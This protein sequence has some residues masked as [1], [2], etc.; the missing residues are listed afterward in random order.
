MKQQKQ[1]SDS[2]GKGKL[3]GFLTCSR[4]GRQWLRLI[5]RTAVFAVLLILLVNALP[6]LAIVFPYN[7]CVIIA[8]ILIRVI[9]DVSGA[10]AGS[11]DT[12][13]TVDRGDGTAVIAD[14][15]EENG[16]IGSSFLFRV[17]STQQATQT[18]KP[19]KKQIVIS[20][21]SIGD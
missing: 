8:V 1:A 20:N 21:K 4:D 3:P 15:L 11:R 2:A 12:V 18:S 9:A 13:F 14:R 6:E 16:L 7:T 10:S 17:V 5:L 19:N